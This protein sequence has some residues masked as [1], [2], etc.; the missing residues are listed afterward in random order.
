[1]NYLFSVPNLLSEKLLV[2]Q[3]IVKQVSKDKVFVCL[4]CALIMDGIPIPHITLSTIKHGQ[5]PKNKIKSFSKA[6]K[7][8]SH[9]EV[10]IFT[11][12]HYVFPTS[13]FLRS[14]LNQ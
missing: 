4:S 8:Y 7:C 3:E 1:M 2:G 6:N 9:S 11:D 13:S 12:Y 14:A 10:H 5:S